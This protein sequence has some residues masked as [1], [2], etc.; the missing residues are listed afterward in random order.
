[1]RLAGTLMITDG[2]VHDA[3]EL[4]PQESAGEAPN[5]PLHVL[6]TG[7]EQEG[8][9]R[10]QVIEAPTFG[11]VGREI[12]VVIRVDDLLGS[13]QSS[14]TDQ[15]RVTIRRD[16][17]EIESTF[18]P[19]GQETA[20]D[21]TLDHAGDT[22]LEIVTDE[23]PA[24]LSLANNRA[25]LSV[26]GVRERLRVLLVSGEPHAGERTWRSLLKADPSVDLVH[27]TILRPPEKQD[28]TPI[29]E[30]SLIAFPI[31][32]LFEVKLDEFDLIIFDRYRRRGVVPRLYLRNISEYVFKGGALLEA[33]GPNFASPLTLHRT[34]L[35]EVLPGAPTGTIFEQGYQPR[36]TDI[37]HRHPV[38]TGL[39]G[40][41]PETEN[42]DQTDPSWGRWFRQIEVDAT[43]GETLMT[44]LQNRPLLILDR[45]GEGRVA[46]V[47]SDHMWLWSRGYEGGGPQAELLR[48]IAHWLMKEPEL[49]EN[50][51]RATVRGEEIEITRRSLDPAEASV[52]VTSPS[53]ETQR[54]TLEAAGGGRSVGRFVPEELGLY[55]TEDGERV[56]LTAVGPLNPLE[57]ADLRSSDAVMRPLVDASGGGVFRTGALQSSVFSG[58]TGEE[59]AATV[60]LPDIRMVAQGRDTTG[61]DWVGLV[62]NGASTVT[63]VKEI[64]L[65]PPLA[66]LILAIGFLLLAWRREGR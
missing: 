17:E 32:E 64:P 25:V 56:A 33:A 57:F 53:G 9:R 34:P 20:L 47:M 40:A 2:V 55:R 54:I 21:V 6:L 14:A 27:F 58:D 43:S 3:P 44:G 41:N 18:I 29:R 26:N 48:R 22:I 49:E 62:R 4:A 45:V 51:L 61:R 46:Q 16:G 52:V 7:S 35:G 50:D 12:S 37:G 15:A 66:A 5:P 38:T 24:E 65:L 39:S 11:L 13:Q 63:G 30:L 23:G 59:A 8:D 42:E 1:R 36:V 60:D 28:G 19:L 10:L 31:R